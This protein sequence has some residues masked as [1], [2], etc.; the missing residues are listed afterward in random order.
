MTMTKAFYAVL[1]SI[2]TKELLDVIQYQSNDDEDDDWY[3]R[4]CRDN[5]VR[6]SYSYSKGTYMEKCTQQE[7]RRYARQMF[8]LMPY[9]RLHGEIKFVRQFKCGIGYTFAKCPEIITH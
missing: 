5:D 7:A 2:R 6:W 4:T 3:V 1:R 8:G 9:Q